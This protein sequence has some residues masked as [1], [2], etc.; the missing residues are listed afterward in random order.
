MDRIVDNSM[1]KK[2]ICLRCGNPLTRE[3]LIWDKDYRG[4]IC[5]DKTICKKLLDGEIVLNKAFLRNY[6][7]L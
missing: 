7:T 1:A 2:K 6:I 4:L 3:H 5:K